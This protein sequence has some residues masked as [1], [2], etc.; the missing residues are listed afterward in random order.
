MGVSNDQPPVRVGDIA[1]HTKRSKALRAFV[2][3]TNR[4]G[5][6]W[7]L[8]SEADLVARLSAEAD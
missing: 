4:G 5:R 6:V 7:F 1:A 2:A 3:E 8:A